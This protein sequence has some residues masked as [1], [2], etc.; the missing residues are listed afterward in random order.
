M[1]S[2]LITYDLHSPGQDY[3]T[4]FDAIKK[5]GTWWHCLDSNWIVKSDSSA[6]TIRDS[7]TPYIDSNDS[8]LVIA[9]TG[10]AA[11]IGFTKECS[12][13]LKNNL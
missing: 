8:L 2:Y 11:W 5:V 9:L 12:D 7:I 4:L 1:K 10:E 3:S 6:E 13:W